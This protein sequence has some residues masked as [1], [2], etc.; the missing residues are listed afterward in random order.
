[1]NLDWCCEDFR[2]RVFQPDGRQDGLRIVIVIHSRT[3]PLF[4]LE[5]RRP[6]RK[7]TEPIAEDG[8]KLKFCPRCGGN[9]IERYR[10]GL[11]PFHS[12]SPK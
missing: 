7:S 4:L 3:D 11:P 2:E 12:E 9:L 1:M 8:I 10:S 6:N 5:Y